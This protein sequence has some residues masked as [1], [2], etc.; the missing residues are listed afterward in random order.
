MLIKGHEVFSAGRDAG[1]K[2]YFLY[3][4]PAELFKIKR[5]HDDGLMLICSVVI[6]FVLCD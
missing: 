1:R 4:G 6:V 5:K 3:L 2:P